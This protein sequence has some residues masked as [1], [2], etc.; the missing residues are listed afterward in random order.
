MASRRGGRVFS[1][2]PGRW[3]SCTT[4]PSSQVS[5]DLTGLLT[6]FNGFVFP[7][8][9]ECCREIATDFASNQ[10]QLA[11]LSEGLP[12]LHKVCST[13][14]QRASDLC[15]K[16]R[17]TSLVLGQHTKLLE[18][19]ELPQLIETC[20][21]NSHYEE[22]LSILQLA[23]RLAKPMGSIPLVGKIL[24]SINVSCV[25]MLNQLLLRLRG[26]VQLPECLRI[27]GFIRRMDAFTDTELRIKFLQV[28]FQSFYR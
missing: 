3:P 14:E 21:R 23:S 25:W 12:D 13:F 24:D 27:V 2:R 15:E 11:S 17:R 20:V 10:E 19:L 22:A 7:V 6:L 26:N 1:N 4:P 8:A 9:A 16:R 28:I 5:L 18:I